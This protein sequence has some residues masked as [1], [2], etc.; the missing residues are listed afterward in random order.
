M[1][2]SLLLVSSSRIG[3][4]FP[5]RSDHL[6]KELKSLNCNVIVIESYNPIIGIITTIKYWKIKW[7]IFSGFRAGIAALILSFIGLKW[8]YDFVEIKSKL[9][10][11]NW[12][13]IKKKFIPII[14]ILEKIM[15]KRANL[16]FSA[17][18]SSYNYAKNIKDKVIL[19]PNGYDEKLFDLNKYDRKLLR[20]YYKVNF[21]LAIYIGKL[22]PMYAK[23]L[24]KAIKAM[25]FVIKE[26]PNAEFWIFGDGLSR[27]FLEKISNKNVKFKGY[28]EYEKVP[29][30]I[31]IADVGIHAYDSEGL[32]LIEWLAMGLPTIFPKGIKINNVIECIWEPEEIAKKLIYIFKNPYRNPI[33]M[34]TWRESAKLIL[35]ILNKLEKP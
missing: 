15:I 10:R 9:C 35:D 14:E 32:K 21:P 24:I 6:I 26:I 34:P 8:I 2:N 16:V 1:E 13:G 30:I 23:F 25:D 33:R 19:V 12:N 28:I 20:N 5:Q 22:T 11:D 4:K 18:L 29:E 31:T 7:K 17:G 27:K 3:G